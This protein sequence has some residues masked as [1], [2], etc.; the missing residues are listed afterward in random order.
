MPEVETRNLATQGS[1]EV[2]GATLVHATN[3]ALNPNA[4]PSGAAAFVSNNVAV[5]TV[6]RQ[7]AGSS[8]NPQGITTR[9]ASAFNGAQASP[10][11]MNMYNIDGAGNVG[12]AS[13]VGAWV[14]VNASGYEAWLGTASETVRTPIAN[15]VWTWITGSSAAN[16]YMGAYIAKVSG[17][18]GAS[19]VAYITGVTSVIGTVVPKATIAGGTP[20]PL[21]ASPDPDLFS[22]FTSTANASQSAL[23]AVAPAGMSGGIATAFPVQSDAW[24][25]GLGNSLRVVPKGD[26]AG[27]Y[28]QLVAAG[29]IAGK[30]Y[31]FM[32]RARLAAVQSGTLHGNA[33]RFYTGYDV[34]NFAIAPNAAGVHEL[35]IVVTATSVSTAVIFYNGSLST[36]MW[37]DDLTIVEGVYDGPPFSGNSPAGFS[38]DG[39]TWIRYGWEGTAGASVAIRTQ[40]IR[41]T[42]FADMAP[43]PRVLVDAGTH[44]F[45][46]GAV[47]VSLTCTVE[48]RVFDVRGGQRLPA[49]SPA[50]VLDMQAPFGV[51]AAYTVVGYDF[52]GNVIGS[53]PIGTVTLIYEGTVIQQ[54]LDARLSVEVKRL[55]STATEIGRDSPGELVYPQ[56]SVLPGLIGLGP[57][58]GVDGLALDVFVPS[59]DDADALQAT[60]GTY[61]APQLPIWLVR[62]PPPQRIPRLFFCHVP[63]LVERGTTRFNEYVLLSAVVTEVRQ[64]AAGIAGAIL[65]YSDLAV[66]FTSYAALGTSYATYS[67]IKRDTSLVG[68]ADA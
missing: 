43:V 15:G 10:F 67:D 48:G 58:R 52:V 22:V 23:S 12:P 24:S 40:E 33:R 28:G 7:T 14:Y 21:L 35:R 31:T 1:F 4:V 51:Q 41:L 34:N 27:S 56:G 13:V 8:T 59:H 19:D 11:I 49:G 17:N 66:F 53:F 6:T 29:L 26:N 32:V 44:L 25:S 62:S 55:V 63:R 30:T 20:Y 18:A 45:P 61:G 16:S 68:A 64:P 47:T 5:W 46:A 37:W 60:L 65:T 36:D 42:P 9:A 39:S 54:P 3:L 2:A 38:P 57:R 50:V